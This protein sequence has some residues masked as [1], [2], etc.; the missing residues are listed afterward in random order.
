[1]R[2]IGLREAL[3]GGL[4]ALSVAAVAYGAAAGDT[5]VLV[6]GTYAAGLVLIVWLGVRRR[7]RR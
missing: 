4:G 7:R 1:M 3:L 6:A 2:S 5:W